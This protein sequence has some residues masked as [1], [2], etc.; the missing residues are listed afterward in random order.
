MLVRV[1]LLSALGGVLRLEAHPEIETALERLNAQIAAAPGDADL[2]LERGELYAKHSDWLAAEA[3]YLVAAEFA[4]R[5]PGI[6]RARGA[7]ALATGNPAAARVFL[8]AALADQPGDATA[9]VLR[10]RALTALPDRRAAVADYDAAIALV[11]APAP[12]LLLERA[13]LL[14]PPEALRSLD[15]GLARIGPAM[16]LHLRAL[17]LEESLGRIDAAVAR[18]ERIA[19]QSERKE[20][21]LKLQGD[22]LARAGRPG[23]ARRAYAA[24]LSAVSDLPA[25]LRE[26]PE[27]VRLARELARLA[28]PAP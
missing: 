26:S 6:A 12:E 18:L 28:A 5:H 4:P 19:A 14:D 25:W 27:C 13:A 11:A 2:Y 9:R 22:V 3:N 23:E 7:L 15:E 21:W 1:L 16:S 24:A 17:A 10:A 8:D 20:T